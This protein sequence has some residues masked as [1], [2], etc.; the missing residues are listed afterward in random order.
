MKSA[1]NTVNLASIVNRYVVNVRADVNKKME[2]KLN[3]F[4]GKNEG[5]NKLIAI[6]NNQIKSV[7]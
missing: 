4:V 3:C 1:L 7:I 6:L 5:T 2:E